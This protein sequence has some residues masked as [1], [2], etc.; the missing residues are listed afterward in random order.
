MKKILKVAS[1]A[2]A[3]VILSLCFSACGGNERESEFIS[4]TFNPSPYTGKTQYSY[5]SGDSFSKANT[6]VGLKC[7]IQEENTEY[8]YNF[9][10]SNPPSHIS[11]EV[12]G[13]DSSV[14]VDSQTITVKFTSSKIPG[15]ITGT[16]NI[17]ILP[18][19]VTG[20]ELKDETM[21]KKT[22]VVGEQ[23]NY[24]D[25][26]LHATYGN[27]TEG[28]VPVT[29]DMVSGFDTT[30]A[31]VYSNKFTIT[32]QG[33]TLSLS[34]NVVPNENYEVFNGVTS[35]GITVNYLNCFVPTTEFGYEKK[36]TAQNTVKW[37][38]ANVASIEMGFILPQQT[39]SETKI[40]SN[41]TALGYTNA[42]VSSCINNEVN[43]S[44]DAT[45][46]EFTRSGSTAKYKAICF[47]KN[48]K[49]SQGSA[50]STMGIT[51]MVVFAN[52]GG[53]D[54]DNYAEANEM[55]ETVI[56]SMRG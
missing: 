27:G 55:I 30:T 43:E 41:L 5:Y 54:E 24:S 7:Y 50:S 38:K 23:L 46:C 35:N 15:E 11:Y 29:A 56:N 28:D 13:F 40:K 37:T 31:S 8:T 12:S 3:I 39:I 45:V 22:Y 36:T 47:N 9:S 51:V 4:V 52:L 1:L 32:Y 49:L 19:Q 6:C 25:I 42:Q 33:K 14:P 26:I 16:F 2:F 18:P 44:L 17:N 21:V 53:A 48:V 34:Y 20:F 10:L